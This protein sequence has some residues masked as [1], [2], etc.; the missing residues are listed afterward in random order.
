[1]H[2]YLH[3]C[4]CAHTHS[5]YISIL[6]SF[7][8]HFDVEAQTQYSYSQPSPYI[9]FKR[10]HTLFNLIIKLYCRLSTDVIILHIRKGTLSLKYKSLF[11]TLST[12]NTG[13]GLDLNN[14]C[15]LSS[16][17]ILWENVA[18]SSQL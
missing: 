9:F 8:S 2:T 6:I 16:V 4:T 10:K 13:A 15:S 14:L 5:A 18:I 1:M 7:F 11:C 12:I 3:A 17:Q